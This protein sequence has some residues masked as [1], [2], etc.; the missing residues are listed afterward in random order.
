M[1]IDFI[2]WMVGYAEGFRIKY[3]NVVIPGMATFSIKEHSEY[4]DNIIYPLL[5]QK[6]IEGIN[7]KSYFGSGQIEL[8]S[9]RWG[10]QIM[11]YSTDNHEKKY[12]RFESDENYKEAALKY[13]F[14]QEKK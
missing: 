7:K 5:R 1:N 4:F 8:I 2:K 14:E 10:I 12:F 13:I 11:D 3:N 6:A 9:H